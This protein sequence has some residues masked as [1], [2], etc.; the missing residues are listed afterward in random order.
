MVAT[1]LETFLGGMETVQKPAGVL[2]SFRLE[3]FL[4]GMET[5]DRQRYGER[6]HISL[7]PSLVEWKLRA[8]LLHALAYPP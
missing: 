6:E 7:K 2:Q 5:R 3:T 8:N 1:T 4:G